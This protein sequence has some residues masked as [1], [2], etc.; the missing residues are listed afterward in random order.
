MDL[1]HCTRLADLC[2]VSIRMPVKVPA[3]SRNRRYLAIFA[4]VLLFAPSGVAAKP[5]GEQRLT[6]AAQGRPTIIAMI[7][8]KGPFSFVVDTGSSQTIF[9]ESLIA[10]LGA[11]AKPG[12]P[13]T[14]T[15]A[16]GS[17]TSQLYR[18]RD[19]S[20]AG[21]TLNDLDVVRSPV[22]GVV[23]ADGVF[24]SDFLSNFNVELDWAGGKFRLYPSGV[25]PDIE[26]FR[27]ARGKL[28]SRQLL[29][30]NGR[31]RNVRC[32]VILDTGGLVSL[33]NPALGQVLPPA[34]QPQVA[35]DF[36]EV[37][38][39]QTSGVRAQAKVLTRLEIGGLVWS[40]R[41]VAI[42]DLPVFLQLEDPRKPAL[43]LGLD[44]LGKGHMVIDY[45]RA[46]VYMKR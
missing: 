10:A 9:S 22:P 3:M 45:D 28:D 26:G 2:S 11:E 44:I 4:L 19:I 7:G 5:F 42:A 8:E 1:L 29:T 39:L 32:K 20:T 33:G 34:I 31:C 15:T 43:F 46:V 27:L 23:K 35:I 21:V 25:L 12:Q 24:G 14:V 36:L 30:M 40:N 6:G 41:D 16:S 13:V 38:G 37:N 18:V 17:I